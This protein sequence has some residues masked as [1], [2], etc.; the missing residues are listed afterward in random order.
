MTQGRSAPMTISPQ[1]PDRWNGS[2]DA[3]GRRRRESGV[4]IGGAL[5]LRPTAV[6]NHTAT[7]AALK[8]GDPME[9]EE[10]MYR[11]LGY[12]EGIVVDVQ[13]RTPHREMPAF[14]LAGTH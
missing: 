12:F 8:R 10:E 11:H 7:L 2:T 5:M 13:R 9:I 3:A 4:Q 14:L 1:H 6:R